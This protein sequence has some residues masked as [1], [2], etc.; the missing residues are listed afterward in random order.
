MAAA[1]VRGDPD[2]GI[3]DLIR[4]LTQDSKRLVADEVRLAKIDATDSLHRAARGVLWMALAFGVGVVMFVAVTLFVAT[5][6]GR[7]ANGHMWI[8]ALVTGLLE[9]GVGAWLVK[10]GISA[11]IAPSYSLEASRNALADT[12][13]WMTSGRKR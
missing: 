12:A 13:N 5:L 10:R 11:M 3:P 9:I 2:L 1:P 8:G 4:R 6:I 7:A